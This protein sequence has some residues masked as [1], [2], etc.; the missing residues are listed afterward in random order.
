MTHASPVYIG[1][2]SY[3]FVF[4]WLIDQY[5]CQH[6]ASRCTCKYYK[7]FFDTLVTTVVLVYDLPT[8]QISESNSLLV[9]N[10]LAQ[11][12]SQNYVLYNRVRLLIEV[13]RQ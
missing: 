9:R 8:A 11:M 4:R 2:N 12:V 7:H 6:V 5:M 1:C 13:I 3:A 10:N